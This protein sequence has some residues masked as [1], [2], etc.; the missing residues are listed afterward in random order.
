MKK[1]LLAAAVVTATLSGSVFAEWP[2]KPI[3][4]IVPF[5]AGGTS[6]Q[7]GRVTQAG[8]QESEALSQPVTI[9]N[10]GGH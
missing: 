8:I 1:I 10:V 3:K 5:K 2:E 6:D 4:L 9:V 7:V